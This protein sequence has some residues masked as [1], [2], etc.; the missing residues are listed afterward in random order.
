LGQHCAPSHP[1]IGLGAIS[2][3]E[4]EATHIPLF[5]EILGSSM[6][7]LPSTAACAAPKL[8]T[9]TISLKLICQSYPQEASCRKDNRRVTN[10][11]ETRNVTALAMKRSPSV[12]PS[13]LLAMPYSD[14]LSLTDHI[15]FGYSS[16]G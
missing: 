10:S 15:N 9:I 11:A 3:L 1:V 2:S 6:E 4:K 8:A 13:G 5:A 12:D 7:R 16:D 14:G